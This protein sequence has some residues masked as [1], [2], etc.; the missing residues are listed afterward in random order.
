[1][2]FLAVMLQSFSVYIPEK[3][4]DGGLRPSTRGITCLFP[5]GCKKS[6]EHDIKTGYVSRSDVLKLTQYEDAWRQIADRD[7]V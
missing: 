5:T 7:A 3:P 2:L 6:I 4:T 1:M